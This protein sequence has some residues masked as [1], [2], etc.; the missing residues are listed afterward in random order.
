[1]VAS[2]LLLLYT[3]AWH[4][5]AG[6]HIRIDL[7][8]GMYRGRCFVTTRR[9]LGHFVPIS[10]FFCIQ[11]LGMRMWVSV[12]ALIYRKVC[13][14]G[15]V[16]SPHEGCFV[17]NGGRFCYKLLFTCRA[18]FH[19]TRFGG[20]S[21]SMLFTYR[22]HLCLIDIHVTPDGINYLEVDKRQHRRSQNS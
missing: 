13:I 7:Q 10:H 15:A 5:C 9:V 12:S 3:E 14:E 20:G 21:T 1:M 16:L 6:L 8:E 22:G 4:A 11:R 17:M 2:S 19:C 18:P